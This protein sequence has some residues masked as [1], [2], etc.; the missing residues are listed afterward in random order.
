MTLNRIWAEVLAC[1]PDFAELQERTGYL[2]E[3]AL[4]LY[5][6]IHRDSEPTPAEAA[7]KKKKRRTRRT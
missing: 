6:A 2:P 1:R 4:R 5:L 3:E 7:V